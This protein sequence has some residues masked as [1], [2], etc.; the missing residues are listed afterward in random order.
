EEDAKYYEAEVKAGRYL[1]TVDAK[2][3]KDEAW[4]ILRRH[5]AY[6]KAHPSAAAEYRVTSPA[7]RTMQLKEEELK[8]DKAP[9][10]TGEVEV[11]KEVVTEH[12]QI[13]V[14]VEREEVV[15]ERRPVGRK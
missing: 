8:V 5:G 9:V 1:V 10:Q 2:D 7:G 13:S 15:I 4:E 12:R 3:R 11:R 14:P 6:N